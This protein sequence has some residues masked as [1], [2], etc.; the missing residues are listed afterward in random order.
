LS[1][2]GHG[3]IKKSGII[4]LNKLIYTSQNDDLYF[5]YKEYSNASDLEELRSRLMKR[6]NYF[7]DYP[8]KVFAI[9]EALY[10]LKNPSK[11][12]HRT[13]VL[14]IDYG[15]ETLINPDYGLEHI[16][17]DGGK[18][19]HLPTKRKKIITENLFKFNERNIT[20]V[21]SIF[22]LKFYSLRNNIVTQSSSSEERIDT[23]LTY[24]NETNQIDTTYRSR[25]ITLSINAP[26]IQQIRDTLRLRL[27]EVSPRRDI[28][29]PRR[30]LFEIND[31]NPIQMNIGC[32]ERLESNSYISFVNNEQFKM[33]SL[34]VSFVNN[35]DEVIGKVW[36][37]SNIDTVRRLALDLSLKKQNTKAKLKL[38]YWLHRKDTLYG[39]MIL[40]PEANE[41]NVS[42]HDVEYEFVMPFLFL[43][44]DCAL[45]FYQCHCTFIKSQFWSM[46][47]IN[48]VI[49]M[50]G[51]KLLRPIVID[52]YF[53]LEG[54]LKR[55][56]KNEDHIFYGL[57]K[58]FRKKD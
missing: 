41:Y 32:G 48:I 18:N 26:R 47:I 55:A 34:T 31:N 56:R 30:D 13:I 51:I 10:T 24:N 15:K 6:S 8:V 12:V 49:I 42:L 38:R 25:Y 16:I 57:F 9:S 39:A 28:Q 5:E 17:R 1:I 11:K 58:F 37:Y 40:S 44:E 33:D 43:F 50:F 3:A 36:P 4:N 46:L 53:Y 14:W 35:Q 21:D 7:A 20:P 19:E 45:S 54:Q 52:C 23:I 29:I 27:Y 2:A 22:P